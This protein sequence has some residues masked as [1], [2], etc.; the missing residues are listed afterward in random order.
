MGLILQNIS[1]SGF[2]SY[3]PNEQTI[4]GGGAGPVAVVGENGAG[5][6]T[7]VSKALTWCLYGKC[8]PERMGSGMRSISGKSVVNPACKVAQVSVEFSDGGKEYTVTRSR[9][10]SGSDTVSVTATTDGEVEVLEPTEATIQSI[11]GADWFVFTRTVVRGQGDV[12]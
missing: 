3:G 8:A 12:L 2:G 11:V 5:K 10:R 6:S 9:K 4:R 1:L 7:A